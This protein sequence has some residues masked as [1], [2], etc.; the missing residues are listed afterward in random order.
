MTKQ[1]FPDRPWVMVVDDEEVITRLL[2][3][4][5]R[6]LNY[7]SAVAHSA[8]EA[9]RVMHEAPRPFDLLIADYKMPQTSGIELAAEVHSAY[10]AMPIILCTGDDTA[11]RGL[12][13]GRHGIIAVALK[14]LT[15]VEFARLLE[16]GLDTGV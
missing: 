4:Q 11:L 6:R 2:E 12:D 10:P 16:A 15:P 9:L 7:N 3:T 1:T 8:A 14:P 13:L 5:L